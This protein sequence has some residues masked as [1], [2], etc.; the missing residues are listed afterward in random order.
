MYFITQYIINYLETESNRYEMV[1]AIKWFHLPFDCSLLLWFDCCDDN[2][3]KR[4]RKTVKRCPN[5]DL[6]Y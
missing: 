2:V 6:R 4:Q 3:V 5:V 1:N